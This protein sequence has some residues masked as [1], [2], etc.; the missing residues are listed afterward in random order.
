MRPQLSV[1]V[2]VSGSVLPSYKAG[3]D[4]PVGC[5]DAFSRPRL[6]SFFGGLLLLL[7][8]VPVCGIKLIDII[9]VFSHLM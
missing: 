9:I 3:H 4:I 8:V 6:W 2:A 5:P 7:A 1:L